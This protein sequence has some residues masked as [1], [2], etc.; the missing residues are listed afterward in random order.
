MKEKVHKWI[1]RT[2]LILA[3]ISLI[4][5][6]YYAKPS[7][8]IYKEKCEEGFFNHDFYNDCILLLMDW[9]DLMNMSM[10]NDFSSMCNIWAIKIG[11]IKTSCER[12]ESEGL[13]F[14]FDCEYNN[15]RNCGIFL[16]KKDI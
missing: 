13:T 15:I 11:E 12:F 4:L 10:H 9:E 5:F 14:P 1:L 3:G 16:L 2:L 7:I 8:A 6:Y